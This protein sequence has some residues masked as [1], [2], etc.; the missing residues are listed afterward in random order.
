MCEQY[1]EPLRKSKAPR[2]GE[3]VATL[4][5]E[6]RDELSTGHSRP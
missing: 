3:L 5:R 6:R 4:L 2:I 1:T